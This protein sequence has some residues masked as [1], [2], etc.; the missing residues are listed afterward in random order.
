MHRIALFGKSKHRT[1]TT[2]HLVRA[3]RERGNKVLWLNPSKIRR[4][5]KDRTDR[6]ILSQLR[7]FNPHIVFVYSQDI[8]LGVL[9]KV[10][11][12]G[13]VTILYY[14]DWSPEVPSSMAEKGKLVNFFLVTNKGMHE[15]YK[16]AGIK[17]PI[18]FI[19]ACDQYDHRP[20]R[21]ILP[22]W[23]SDVA[24][25]G[26]ARPGEARLTLVKRFQENFSVKV[27]GRNW[28]EFGLRST[29]KSV[30][31]R[32]YGLICG[33]AKIVLGAD[34]TNQVDGYWSNR[35]WLTLGS[36]GFFLTA[37]VQGM[38]H[39]FENK[40]HLVWYHSP[41]ECLMLAQEYMDK[42]EDRRAIARQGYELVHEQH[43]FHHFADRVI[44]LCRH[45][46]S[47]GAASG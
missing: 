38:E 6:F 30:T 12:W 4:Q 2:A 3:F 31:P 24:F 13:M 25:I 1:R 7:T 47:E 41:E 29:L 19:G 22:L 45:D 20:R 18:Y 44:A 28:S 36:G 27:Y 26:K 16:A 23:K 35:L 46:L 9:E 33:G 21:P 34:I 43:T 32:G 37:Y 8:P 15:K 5:K 11:A 17:N 40:K 42:P 10:A 14:E 39:F